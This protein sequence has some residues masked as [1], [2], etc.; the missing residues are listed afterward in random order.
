MSQ[1]LRILCRTERPL[2]R[3]EI[4][5]FIHEGWFFNAP[6]RFE[7]TLDAPEAAHLEWARFEVHPPGVG[8]PIVLHYATQD[9]LA[10]SIEELIQTLLDAGLETS[11]AALLQ[12]IRASRQ[13]ITI[14]VEPLR[15]TD[16]AWEMLDAT[17]AFVARSRDG[18]VF[19]SGEAVYDAALQPLCVLRRPTFG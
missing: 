17:E 8:R 18:V 12:R 7:P 4:G 13:L 19:V 15:M 2:P 9:V 14:E 10:H 5:N 3:A 16:D 11:H 6:P 1:Y